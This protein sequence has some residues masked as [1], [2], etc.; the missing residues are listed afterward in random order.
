MSWDGHQ[1]GKDSKLLP[2]TVY[3]IFTH[4]FLPFYKQIMDYFIQRDHPSIPPSINTIYNLLRR[5]IIPYVNNN[6]ADIFSRCTSYSVPHETHSLTEPA[7]KYAQSKITRRSCG[8][9]ATAYALLV[10]IYLKLPGQPKFKDAR[11][12]RLLNIKLHDNT[13]CNITSGTNIAVNGDEM[14]DRIKDFFLVTSPYGKAY[15]STDSIDPYRISPYQMTCSDS[16]KEIQDGPNLMTLFT[17]PPGVD[18]STNHHFFVYKEGDYIV[19]AD[20]WANSAHGNRE[21][22]VRIMK[23]TEF[24]KIL[25][26]IYLPETNYKER[27]KL[28]IYYFNVPYNDYYRSLYCENV[29][30]EKTE[31]CDIR[32]KYT[33]PYPIFSTSINNVDEN[34]LRENT[35]LNH[36]IAMAGFKRHEELPELLNEKRERNEDIE[37]NKQTRLGGKTRRHKKRKRR[38]S[39]RK[40]RHR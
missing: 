28:M 27:T 36:L 38:K 39:K 21:G 10:G 4:D 40:I 17:R 8:F 1:T 7:I 19:I 3:P 31:I 37:P 12:D 30:V 33:E 35:T 25:N 20:A 24:Q 13:E 26:T 11:F 16:N 2:E 29:S 22:W 15:E 9:N 32:V 34:Y 6:N 18:C 23:S 14:I 5:K